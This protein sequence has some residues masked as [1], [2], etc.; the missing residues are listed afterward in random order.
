MGSTGS[1]VTTRREMEAA[2]AEEE[3]HL[4]RPQES[5]RPRAAPGPGLA[6]GESGG[7]PLCRLSGAQD[8]ELKLLQRGVLLSELRGCWVRLRS[9]PNTLQVR[10][11]RGCPALC[12]P[13]STSVRVDGRSDCPCALAG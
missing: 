13:V 1:G 9:N 6:K 5:K 12:G 8:R 2:A 10:D 7:P 3:I 11:C 4:S